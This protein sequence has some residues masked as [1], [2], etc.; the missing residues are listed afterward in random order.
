MKKAVQAMSNEFKENVKVSLQKMLPFFMSLCFVLVN[1]M[2]S[3]IGISTNF[4]PEIG[5]ICVFYWILNRPDLFNLFMVFFLG[6]ISNIISQSPLGS[7]IIAYLVIY[8]ILNN[9]SSFFYNKPFVIVWYGFAFVFIIAEL[10]K[11]LVVSVYYAQFLPI[12]RLFFIMLF[13]IAAYP[14]IALLN[15]L[16]Q[17][18][19]MNDE[20]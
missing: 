14:V 8:V 3:F 11:W 12:S 17:R 13:T 19:L 7:D 6:F 1:Y 5:M 16:I 4:R 9:L 2:P 15:D 20:A 10:V 18:F